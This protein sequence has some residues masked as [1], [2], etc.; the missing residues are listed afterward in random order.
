MAV[1]E[2][3]AWLELCRVLFRSVPVAFTLK[4]AL[5][6]G[7]L[8]KL[9]GAVATMT[10]WFTVRLA[11][12]VTGLPQVPLKNTLYVPAS[13]VVIIGMLCELPISPARAL[14]PLYH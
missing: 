12:L 8:V 3:W 14:A 5:V 2:V 1:W 9:T 6:P 13:L 10:F 7:Q 4:L 11:L